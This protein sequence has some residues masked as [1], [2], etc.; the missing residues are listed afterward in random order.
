[1]K[2]FGESGKVVFILQYLERFINGKD[3]SKKK[4][5]YGCHQ[6]VKYDHLI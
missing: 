2:T 6:H 4:H 5:V 3:K 1:M